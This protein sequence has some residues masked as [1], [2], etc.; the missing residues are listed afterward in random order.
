M[1]ALT[2]S[3]IPTVGLPSPYPAARFSQ[4]RFRYVKCQVSTQ[5]AGSSTSQLSYD[6][7]PCEDLKSTNTL[8]DK[9]S[10]KV[11]HKKAK[12]LASTF[13][14]MDEDV[15][16]I[17]SLFF[18]IERGHEYVSPYDTAWVAMVPSLDNSQLPQFPQCLSWIM[19]NQLSDGSWG[20]S[21]LP[22]IKDRLSHTLA[23]IIALRTWNI[24]IKNVEMG[25]RFI[26]ENIEKIVD[27]E[28][29]N[30]TGYDLIFTAMLEDA[31]DLFL[32]L[33]YTS[34]PIELM[35][36][37]REEILKS[38]GIDQMDEYNPSLIFT[39]E[40]IH[41]IVDW[42]KVLKHERKDGSLFQ[43]PSATACALMHTRKSSCLVYLNLM[44]ENL[45]NGVPS[46]YPIN[47]IAGLSMVDMLERLGIARHFKYEIKH[48]LDNVY[49]CWIEKEIIQGISPAS[50]IIN[51]SISFR[52][53]R[54]N[55]YDVLPD[56]FLNYLKDDNFLPS[57]EKSG[58]AVTTMLNLYKA[59]Q[60]MF[61]GEIILEEAESFSQNYL[62]KIKENSKIDVKK[63]IHK[64][65]KKE[66][67]YALGVPWVASVE[68]I[69]HRRYIETYDF[70]NI[71][72]GKT[73]YRMPSKRN[74][75]F[76][77]LAKKDYNI[78]QTVFQKDLKELK[79]WYVDCKLGDLPF[80]RQKLVFA[81]F[82][83]AS[84]LFSPEMSAVRIVWTKNLLLT[85]V[86]DDFYDAGG[87]I[88]E[89]QCFLEAVKRW[90]PTGIHNC[91]EDVKILFSTV[92]NTVND[93]SQ[94]A[95]AFQKWDIGT[96][97]REIWYMLAISMMKEAEWAK[98]GHKPSMQEYIKN[99]ET[100]FGVEPMIFTSLCFVGPEI[101][102]QTIH[103]QEHKSLM[104]L[105]NIC[106]RLSNDLRSDKREIKEGK[107]NTQSLF[108]REYPETSVENASEWIRQTINEST[109]ELL[110]KL[111]QPTILPRDCKQMYWATLKLIQLFYLKTDA[112]TSPT[113]M[114]ENI[115]AVL[116]DRVL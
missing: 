115:N 98:T 15:M 80:A 34:P 76:L 29:Y 61:P 19:E 87:S 52:I 111:V 8:F 79:K 112:F 86:I 42:N 68:R 31:K 107:L 102:E 99:G 89:L 4:W 59:S 56:V 28:W 108:M 54:W 84:T 83:A 46:V 5:S 40:G 48:V 37:K 35:L 33:P 45:E 22:Y 100:S 92:Y 91:S 78:C 44:L 32:E 3:V 41:R 70:D 47:V 114:L 49:R 109:V 66:V 30:P 25:L 105:V 69:E 50:D 6:T 57:L 94:D 20:L 65:L 27:E 17:R 97:L 11:V 13:E 101:P 16:K 116:F 24:G 74:D 39:V 53:L 21:Y 103:H 67:D 63:I 10:S 72:I 77:S 82:T 14:C 75:C 104:Q 26:Q 18:E 73:S 58:Q 12:Q 55:G 9:D 96:Q 51:S 106:G 71:Q 7:K 95:R 110:R 1:K 85:L 93:I 90:D 62:T 2:F 43:S 23:C 60:L 88:E 113:E 81:Y 36:T 64:D 38:M